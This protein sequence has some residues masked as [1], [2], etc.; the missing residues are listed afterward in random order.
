MSCVKLFRRTA[1]GI[2]TGQN[3]RDVFPSGEHKDERWLFVVPHDDDAVLGAGLLLQ[4][5]VEDKVAVKVLITTD[6]SLGYCDLETTDDIVAIRMAESKKAFDILGIS[7]VEWLN[8]PDSRLS[9][10]AGRWYVGDNDPTAI[11]G[12]AGLQNAYT[13]YIRNF[14]PTKVFISTFADIHPDHQVTHREMIISLFHA[15]GDIWPE[16]GPALPWIPDAYELAVYCDFTMPPNI[17]LEASDMHIKKKL[18]A[19]NEFHSQRQ[20]VKLVDRIRVEGATEYFR[21]L[22]FNLYDPRTYD[23]LF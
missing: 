5:A 16:L 21:V 13:Y 2:E 7:D 11:K 18:K 10:F 22:E 4:K 3:V 19:I 6:G 17:K 8:L 9:Q 20:M 15:A 23:G 14:K 1:W 12:Y